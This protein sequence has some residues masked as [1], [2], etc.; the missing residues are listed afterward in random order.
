MSALCSVSSD[1]LATLSASDSPISD[2]VRVAKITFFG[3]ISRD[4]ASVEMFNAYLKLPRSVKNSCFFSVYTQC[5][6]DV[7][8][9]FQTFEAF[10][11]VRHVYDCHYSLE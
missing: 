1:E 7:I 3:K 9:V 2:V 6:N 8:R 11:A 10:A 4:T 5:E